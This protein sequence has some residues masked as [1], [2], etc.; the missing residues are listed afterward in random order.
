VH[1]E[2]ATLAAHRESN[3]RDIL[4][5]AMDA[6]ITVDDTQHI[7]FFNAAA[8]AVFGFPREQA[9]GSALA[10]IIPQRFQAGHAAHMQDFGATGVTSRRMGV[11]RI[12][13]A[14]RRNGEEFP[15][16][17][18]IS[19]TIE[20]GRV[21]YT[22]ILRDVTD[23]VRKQEAL[24]RS[25]LDLQQFAYIASHDLKTPLRAVAGFVELLQEQYGNQLDAQ[26]TNLIQRAVAGT[27]RLEQLIDDLLAYSR[28][29]ATPLPCMPVDCRTAFEE[30]VRLLAAAIQDTGAVVTASELPTIIAD[31]AQLIQL[32]QNLIGNGIK[33]HGEQPPQ[34]H[35]SAQRRGS[36]WCFV[37]TDNGIGMEPRHSQRIFEIFRRLHTQQEYPGTGIGLAICQRIVHRHGGSIWV[38][39]QPRIGSS[40]YFTIPDSNKDHLS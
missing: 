7:V 38:E 4:E 25:N 2:N 33:Y 13:G 9:I 40:F 3:L 27:R 16:A 1:R 24:E 12:V 23:Q 31:A 19:K 15:I 14:V 11:G 21:F 34:I 26:A 17:A 35:V 39:S 22:A 6:I 28:L 18:S 36:E 10:E 37:V 32:F 29:H 20:R 30:S 8:E 5:S